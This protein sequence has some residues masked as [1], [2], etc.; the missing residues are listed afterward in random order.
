VI[1]LSGILGSVDLG[2]KHVKLFG[3]V[4]E[5]KCPKCARTYAREE[6]SLESPSTDVSSLIEF[7][8]ESCDEDWKVPVVIRMKVEIANNAEVAT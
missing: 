3:L 6:I 5:S 4:L 2:R 1:R 8:C 7:Y